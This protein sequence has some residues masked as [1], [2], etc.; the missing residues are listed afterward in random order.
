MSYSED[1]MAIVGYGHRLPG[2]LRSDT[3]FWQLLEA[4]EVVR[5]RVEERYG[6]G[7]QPID[8]SNSHGRAGSAYE[9]LVDDDVRWAIDAGFFGLSHHEMLHTT[10]VTRMLL[11]CAW[12]AVEHAGWSLNALRNSPTGVFVGSQTLGNANHRELH[13]AHLFSMFGGSV[14][15]LA[16]RISYHLNLMGP[17]LTVATACSAGLS[18]LHTALNALKTG[19]C[20][21]ALVGACNSLSSARVSIGFNELGVIS[22][23]GRS[24][25][26]GADADGY[27][28]SEGVFFFA[29][30][31]LAAAE[32][33][34]DRVHAVVEATVLNTAGVADG[35]RGLA[36]GRFITAPTQHSQAALMRAAHAQAGRPPRDFDYI[37]AHATGTAVGDRIEGNAIAD[38]FGGCDR[39]LPLRVASVKSNL[40][41]M[42]AAAFHCALLKTVLMMQKR[43]FAPISRNFT[44]PNLEIDFERGNMR[45][46]TACEPFPERPVVVGI[47]SFGFGGANGHCVVSEYRPPEPRVWSVPLTADAGTMVPLSART[48]HMLVEAARDL[49]GALRSHPLDLYTLAGNLARRRTHFPV[50]TAFA[51]RSR[52]Q[53]VE[54]LAEFVRDPDPAS[55]APV[56]EE[57]LR[58]AMVFTGQGAQWAGCGRELYDAHPVFRRV[59]DAVEEHWRVHSDRSLR[60]ACFQASQAELDECELAQP[61]TFML[62]CALVELFKTWGVYPDCVVGHSSGEVAAAYA[63][64]ALSLAD[65]T[66]LVHHRAMLQ[67]RTAGSGRMLVVGLD[68]AGVESLL[69]TVLSCAESGNAGVEIACENSPASTVVCGPAAA[70]Q[71]IMAELDRSGGQYQLIPGNIAFHSSAMEPIHEDVLTSLAF[72]DESGFAPEVPMVSSV[73]GRRVERLDSAYWWDNIRQPVRF[74]AAMER[75]LRDFRPGAILELA[76]HGALQTTIAQCVPPGPAAPVWMPTLMRDSDAGLDFNRALG[77]LF[78]AGYPLDF[79]TQYPRP[80]PIVHLLPGHPMDLS[81]MH[82]PFDDNELFLKRSEL[83]QGP[84]VGHRVDGDAHLFAT[85]LSVAD[86]PWLLDH[87]PWGTGIVPAAGYVELVLEA[88]GGNP[89]YFEEI[90]FLKAR[91]IPEVPVRLQTRLVPV[92]NT[93]NIYQVTISSRPYDNEAV[94][95]VHCRGRVR[96][97]DREPHPDT[98]RHLSELDLDRFER[99]DV[100]AGHEFYERSDAIFET[101]FYGPKFQSLKR[102]CTDADSGDSVLDIEMDPEWWARG[103]A[104]GFVLHPVLL[105]G[106]LQILVLNL[107]KATNMFALPQRARRMTFLKPPTSPRITCFFPAQP[108]LFSKLDDLGQVDIRGEYGEINYLNLGVYDRDTGDLIAFVGDYCTSAA[109]H[110]WSALLQ[111]KHMVSWQPKSLGDVQDPRAVGCR[112]G[113]DLAGIIESLRQT[114]RDGQRV[115]RVVEWAGCRE[116]GQTALRQCAEA[117]VQAE[118][119]TEY[120]L[121]ADTPDVAQ[122]SFDA[123]HRLDAPLRFDAVDPALQPQDVLDRGLL[124]PAAADLQVLHG[125]RVPADAAGWGLLRRLAVPGGL[126]LVLHG[127]AAAIAP[128]AGWSMLATDGEGSLLQASRAEAA[129]PAAEPCSVS[130]WVLGEPGSWAEAWADRW[131]PSDV[132]LAPPDLFDAGDFEW[133]DVL[134]DWPFLF[135]VQAI[136]FF[137]AA[138]PQDPTGEGLVTRFIEFMQAL[139]A[140]RIGNAVPP[141]RLTVVT[142]RAVL[143]VED[144]RGQA[145]WGAVRSMALEIGREVGIDFRLVDLGAREDVQVLEQLVRSDVRESELAVR[146]G[147][148][149]A[150]RIISEE[151]VFNPAGLDGNPAFRLEIVNPGQVDG[152][153]MRTYTPVALD[154]DSVEIQVAAAALNFRD[155][156]VTLNMLPAAAFERSALGNEVGIE[157]SGTVLRAGAG[158]R[159][160]RPGDEVVFSRGGCIANRLVANQANVFPKPTSL[161]LLQGA[162]VLSVYATSYYALLHLA[163]LR[164]G[165]RV[166]IHSALG[167]VGLSAISL[168]K[169]V[170]AEIYATA[171]NEEKRAKLRSMGVRDV[172]DSHSHD[173]YDDLMASTGGEGV[174]VVLNS[175]SGHH[176]ALCLEAL[177]PGGWHCEI[178]KVD[179]YAD[180]ALHMS[181][182][183]KNL[184]FAAIDIDRLMLEEPCLMQDLSRACLEL[185]ETQKAAPLPVT[186]FP[187]RDYGEA[188]RL[189]MSGQHQGKLVLEAPPTVREAGMPIADRQPYLDPE[190]TYLV[191]GG[192]SGVGLHVLAYLAASGARHLTLMDRD[193]ERRRTVEWVREASF[194]S[195]FDHDC[196]I[197]IVAGDVAC[198]DDV[199]RCVANLHR[200]LKGVFHLAGVIDDYLLTDMPPESVAGVFA[201]KAH[202]AL[203]LHRATLACPLDHFVMFSSVASTFGNPA[204]ANYSAA[205]AFLDG[206]ATWRRRQGLPGMSFI[207][208]AVKEV[209]MAARNLHVLRL[210]AVSGVPP[211]STRTCIFN[212]DYAMRTRD[213]RDHLI[214]AVFRNPAWS[215]DSPAYPRTGRLLTNVEAFHLDVGGKFTAEH[216]VEQIAA[217]V[218]ELCGHDEV[219]EEEPLAAYGLT[220]ISVAELGAFFQ[221]QFQFHVSAVELMTT[222]TCL[223]L[224]EAIVSGTSAETS[225]AAREPVE[226]EGEPSADPLQP[227]RR[228]S[229][230]P[231]VF[232]SKPKEHFPIPVPDLHPA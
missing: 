218:A 193:P 73:T 21:Q 39:E 196:R 172:F 107:M 147:R 141:C 146:D 41:H 51:V 67:Q 50:R 87:R 43:T 190:A 32:R 114:D 104:E 94:D 229:R 156:M 231:S 182:F 157:G 143:D 194:L 121:I 122:A 131:E 95:E 153:H 59:V 132:H 80:R 178:G 7:V 96:L 105:D 119:F 25:S 219:N 174:D 33:D 139:V 204:Q 136:D 22:P 89:V 186:V 164:K 140:M 57:E 93:P 84:L 175:L 4:R 130:R 86:Y 24:N 137:C 202:G 154:D 108:H 77:A 30:K 168:A 83:S 72:L 135:D 116:P 63:C 183:R 127:P 162:S 18:A 170:G 181:A 213:A 102:I 53:L 90:E 5:S 144:P 85:R 214:T 150:P 176:V 125:D 52:D 68:R 179:I 54:A 38:A 149:W 169:H 200:P 128:G 46:L 42:E 148:L 97:L 48:P 10:S 226:D 19:D 28:R 109:D 16:N 23:Q 82:D 124:R 171:G 55:G 192:L 166:L 230:R 37:E 220:S 227:C 201:P 81:T 203:H 56:D 133:L 151:A 99:G 117:L 224:A 88:L 115:S 211:V 60:E 15:M 12:E 70:L 62:Q 44:V 61:V 167:G 160:L 17:S 118:G 36:N 222:A 225:D 76:P 92:P 45:V 78:Q 197:D 207:L 66:R 27:M 11:H 180:S 198:E 101:S 209:G 113:V 47:N 205:S 13:G 159:H 14:A 129:S 112:D 9:G 206:L 223:S 232:A 1:A 26:F 29:V 79:R 91:T 155:V 142:Q 31:P 145:L 189:M 165:Q 34:G 103:Q 187:Y 228:V 6:R 110:N 123:F 217:K 185:L 8:P 100:L 71:P 199:R 35:A 158:V 161:T 3:D 106:L 65:A 49:L 138:K 163:R 212:L 173:W 98:P 64:G 177:R 111:S 221:S 126:L 191:T 188:L 120:W 58:L 69:E 210:A 184:R 20:E 152:L 75:I 40:G 134:E 208:S 2:S 216:V 195:R 74:G 215:V